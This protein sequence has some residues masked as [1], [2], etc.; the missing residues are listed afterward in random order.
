MSTNGTGQ[1]SRDDF[2]RAA[3]FS[4]AKLGARLSGWVRD[5]YWIDERRYFFTVTQA[6]DNGKILLVPALAEAGNVRI[7]MP[8]PALVQLVSKVRGTRLSLT[9]LESAQYD[10]PDPATLVVTIGLSAYRIGMASGELINTE[11]VDPAMALYAPDGR[12][13]CFLKDQTVWLKD[14]ESG[15]SRQLLPDGEQHN[16]FGVTPESDTAP[17]MGRRHAMPCGLWSADSEWFATHRIDERHLPESGM[18]EHVPPGGGRPVAH[19]FKVGGPDHPRPA[20]QF[21][22]VHVPSGRT[23]TTGDYPLSVQAFSP[24]LMRGAWFSGGALWFLNFDRFASHVALMKM[25]LA[26]GTL[27]AVLE[28]D[29]SEGWIDVHPL[30][31]GQPI[32]RPV[33]ESGELIWYSQRDGHGHLYLHD[34]TDGSLKNAITAGAWNIRELVHVDAAR[35]RIL[36]LASGF[37]DAADPGHRR[38]CAIDF[39]GTGFETFALDGDVAIKAQPLAG[40]EQLRPFRPSYAA[41]GAS[42]SGRYVVANIGDTDSPTRTV[43]V[44]LVTGGQTSL[45]EVDICTHWQAPLPRRFEVLAADGMTPLHGAMY[46]PSNFDERRSY[47]VID[48]IYPGPQMNW[49]VRRFPSS[50]GAN[51]QSLAELGFVGIVLESRGLPNHS[52]DFH[53]AG[54]GRMLEPQLA[55][56]AAAVEQLCRRYAFLDRSRIGMFGQSG[57]GQATARALFDYPD[58]FKAGV[59]ICGNHDSRNYIALWLDKYGGRPGTPERDAQSNMASAPKLEGKL[60][61]I[62]GAMDENVSV[63]HTLALSDALIAA[64]K[65][66]DQLIVPNSGH[67]ILQDCPY[68]LQRLWSFFGRHLIGVEPPKDFS[69]EYSPGE[70]AAGIQMLLADINV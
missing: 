40:V 61:L 27:R 53:Q 37:A 13:A 3:T 8:P 57:G 55:D 7:I 59:A 64:G 46:L 52:R 5:G 54:K 43:L 21:I 44:D 29:A 68:V 60:F 33:P 66:F 56:H 22:A 70:I 15:T 1:P 67:G 45:G 69:F 12:N 65:E 38:L 30:L 47:P 31:A 50:I 62:H 17:V 10:M 18:V 20:L 63:A 23:V 14:R 36:F 9:E 58:V 34:L 11:P 42:A 6:M 51:L 32:V 39:D 35:R 4:P 41:I 48:Y 24:F 2:A 28:E 16:G 26:T 49:Y 19:L 25:E